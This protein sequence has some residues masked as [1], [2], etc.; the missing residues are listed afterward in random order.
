MESWTWRCPSSNEMI[1]YGK[2]RV[3]HNYNRLVGYIIL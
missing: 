2:V 1:F 3:L